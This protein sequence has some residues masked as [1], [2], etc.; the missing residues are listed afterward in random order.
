MVVFRSVIITLLVF[1]LQNQVFAQEKKPIEGEEA[2]DLDELEEEEGEKEGDD[3][4]LLPVTGTI[5]EV[6]R[7]RWLMLVALVVLLPVASLLV[8]VR[9]KKPRKVVSTPKEEAKK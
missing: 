7:N 2:I 6:E 3:E 9:R 8:P 4:P 5:I 1:S